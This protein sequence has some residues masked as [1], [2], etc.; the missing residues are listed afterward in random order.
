MDP[1][2][3]RRRA[4]VS[5]S[6]PETERAVTSPALLTTAALTGV[7]LIAL[8][9]GSIA[10]TD[11][12]LYA[13]MAREMAEA[14]RWLT[15]TWLGVEVFEKPPL[16]LWL[17][18]LTGPLFDWSEFGLR[19][20]GVLGAAVTLYYVCRLTNQ[21]ATGRWAGAVAGL[22]AVATVT[23]TFN[24]RRPMTDPL[25]CAAVLASLWY[26]LQVVRSPG[27]AARQAAI[28]LGV[29]GGLGL[30]AK[31]VAMGPAALV[32]ALILAWHDRWR[33]I[34]LAT[35]VALLVAGPWFVAMTVA[36]GG[37]FWEVFLGYHVLDRAGGALVGQEP[38]TIYLETLWALDGLLGLGLLLGLVLAPVVRRSTFT[39]LV[40]GTAWVTLIA[41]HGSSTR[42]YHYL[43]PVIPLAA[44][45]VAVLASRRREVLFG[46]GGLAIVAF[47]L[48]PLDPTLLRPNFAPSSKAIGLSL[49]ALP[50]DVTV[51]VWE[52]YDPALTWY[53]GRPTKLWTQSEEMAAIQGSIDMMRRAEA[54]VFATPERLDALASSPH[55]VIFVAP[56]ERAGGLLAW[57]QSTRTPIG[58][59][60]QLSET[61]LIVRLEP[62]P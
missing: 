49:R 14:G 31:W 38:W 60:D 56:R 58:L 57:A 45:C 32:C 24:A 28:G 5:T 52:D 3:R 30:L 26:T 9:Q 48:G 10:S 8:G 6:R 53:L 7:L 17:L 15:A 41:I 33:A 40:A 54:V 13:Q 25:L 43:M 37:V 19:L 55:P 50:D 59:D 12:A 39:A 22:L 11:D 29:A 16:L 27:G 36:H 62:T 1:R 4:R 61:H 44:I 23:F 42:L 35:A 34:G 2:G 21:E 20:P 47:V 51:A 46:V 18:R